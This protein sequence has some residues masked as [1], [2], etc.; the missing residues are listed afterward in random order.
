MQHFDHRRQTVGGA[1]T[2][3]DDPVAGRIEVPV[4]D[5][6]DKG[7]IHHLPGGPE[8][9]P[10]G[11]GPEVLFIGSPVSKG[12]GGFQDDVHPQLLPG[13]AFRI[14]DPG[15]PHFPAV[16]DDVL[17]RGRHRAREPAVDRIIGQEMHIPGHVGPGVDGHQF[18]VLIGGSHEPGE[19]PTDTPEAIDGHSDCHTLSPAKD[20]DR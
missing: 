18:Q 16:N 13:E 10:L 11:P 17:P 19:T 9:D 1:G 2:V 3:G 4:V 20:P 15:N 14:Q 6:I 5:P 12:A 7:A 8:D